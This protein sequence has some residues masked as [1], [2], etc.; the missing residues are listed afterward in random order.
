[1][2]RPRLVWI[3][4]VGLASFFHGGAALADG[5]GRAPAPSPGSGLDAEPIVSSDLVVAATLGVAN[6]AGSET[7]K[8]RAKALVMK[9]T[10][11]ALADRWVEAEALFEDAWAIEKTY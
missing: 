7:A 3:L 6:A 2:S 10:D 11:A 8:E 1:M 4:A 5:A 9:A